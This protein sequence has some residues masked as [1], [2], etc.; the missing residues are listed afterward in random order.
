VALEHRPDERPLARRVEVVRARGDRGRDRGLAEPHERAD[1]RHE[2]VAA[3]H[4]V[5]ERLGPR[6]VGDPRL[7]AAQRRGEPF[8]PVGTAGGEDR[9]QAAVDERAGGQ[10]ARVAGGPEQHDAPAHGSTLS[11]G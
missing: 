10:L 9:A 3:T 4:E 11:S 2:D 6:H 5:A 1:G 8:E 7:Q